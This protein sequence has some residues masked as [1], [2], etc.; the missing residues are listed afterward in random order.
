M[1]H[2]PLL[3]L[4]LLLQACSQTQQGLVDTAK[5]AVMGPDDVTVSDEKIES[6]PYASMYLRIN[7]GQRIFLVLG[8]AEQGQQKWVTQNRAMLVTQQG[9]LVKT[10]GLSDNL[11]EVDNL[12]QDPLAH[13]LRIHEGD[14]WTRIMSWTENGQLRASSA[15]SRFSRG[16]DDVL[17]LA[18]HQIPCRVWHEEITLTASGAQWQNTFWIDASSGEVRQSAQQVGADT[19]PVEITILKPAKS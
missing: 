11:L 2:I 1:R 7:G 14:S 18:G 17:T 15:V 16:Q 19:L 8:Y 6:L 5:L 4:C 10:L 13:P 9:R 3:F 12:Q